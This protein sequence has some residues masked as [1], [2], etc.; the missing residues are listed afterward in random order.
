M[1]TFRARATL[2]RILKKMFSVPAEHHLA[3]KRVRIWIAAAIAALA[4]I[5]CYSNHF[6]SQFHFDD[7]HTI[8][9]NVYIR[10]L[11]NVQKFFTDANTFSTLP[12]NRTW[13]PVVSTSLAIDY[14]L[15][16]GLKPLWFHLSTF[17]WYL[18]Q[19][20][21]MFFLFRRI[22]REVENA[23]WVDYCAL[24]AATWYGLHPA[25][26][27]TV[28]YV[29]QRGDLYST[30]A[31]VASLAIF[32]RF[33]RGRKFGWY[34]IPAVLGMLAKPPAAVFPLI[35]F[36]WI[37]LFEENADGRKALVAL[38]R[39]GFAFLAAGLVMF[40]EAK[41][42]PRSY[43]PGIISAHDYIVTQPFVALHYFFSFFLPVT[44]TADSDL[45]AF[46]TVFT[47]AALAGVVF[48]GLLACGI[49]ATSRKRMTRPISL[50][51]AWFL[52]ALLPT[53]LFPLSEVENDHRMFMPFV[54]LVLAVTWG[55]ALLLRSQ[56]RRRP[57]AVAAAAALLLAAYGQGA[58]RRNRVW[59]TEETLW[60]DVTLKSPRN[61]RGLMNYGLTLM[62]K[63]QTAE[64]L[65]YFLRAARYTPNYY[66]LDINLGIAYGALGN[67]REAEPHFMRAL[68]LAP[69]EGLP[70]YFYGRWLHQIRRDE[71][72][73]AQ[74][75]SSIEK[76]PD[77][78]DARHELMSVYADLGRTKALQALAQNTLAR[79]PQD[80][81]A[82]GFLKMP[83]GPS[84]ISAALDQKAANSPET[85][86]NLS[87]TLNL[88]GKF[89]ES[90]RASEQ[91]LEL[92]PGYAEAWNNI[93][94]GHEA[95]GEW[96]EAVAAAA[97]A[98]ALKPDFQLAKNNLA[99][100]R[101]QQMLARKA[102]SA[103]LA[104]QQSK[105]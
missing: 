37:F 21:T 20:A 103:S 32:V 64:A 100:S 60:K 24:L 19:L 52:I 40:V 23:P 54:G 70:G 27:E 67:A 56:P 41:M 79:L 58:W 43:A 63:G 7:S 28:N 26:A 89:R 57:V 31:V 93:A 13:R 96:N 95:L 97:K 94:A 86:L 46:K 10:S 22:L 48:L 45:S 78:L 88:A 77:Y 12:A 102:I 91:A 8:V 44:L 72:A 47:P 33:P 76:N 98:V 15:G 16:G 53:S 2:R 65:D 49:W 85:L 105:I 84:V 62:A 30:L 50:G 3:Q 11:N 92:R 80:A 14:W 17:L 5:L 83:P 38:R 87:L 73:A 71:E 36:T 82:T 18:I 51:L 34:L 35:L 66:V 90:I 81:M 4:V 75:G 69:G 9:Q 61:G 55:M 101:Q 6:G 1:P 99:Y 25:M 39:S 42:T 74:L 104:K 59:S 29:I 68:H